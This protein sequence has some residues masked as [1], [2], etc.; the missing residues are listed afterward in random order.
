[1]SRF[2]PRCP[3]PPRYRSRCPS[4]RQH[5][6]EFLRE[7]HARRRSSYTTSNARYDTRYR[8]I[9]RHVFARRVT[10]VELNEAISRPPLSDSASPAPP[11]VGGISHLSSFSR[12]YDSRPEGTESL[13]RRRLSSPRRDVAEISR[14]RNKKIRR[15]KSIPSRTSVWIL[16][17]NRAQRF[18][19]GE[20]LLRNDD[21]T[22]FGVSLIAAVIKHGI[23]NVKALLHGVDVTRAR[24][25]RKK[26][27]MENRAANISR[28]DYSAGGCRRY[29]VQYRA[30]RGHYLRNN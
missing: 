15:R 13:F 9:Q 8:Y 1:M 3:S 19:I 11:C 16:A 24:A 5:P 7:P 10:L 23:I 18:I 20:P 12:I 2:V 4:H 30:R 22:M 29:R 17:I 14:R 25:H 26:K 27:K 21:P 6:P 28:A